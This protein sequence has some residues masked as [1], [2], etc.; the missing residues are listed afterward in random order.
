MQYID[1]L[2]RE[3]DSGGLNFWKGQLDECE[4]LTIPELTALG[5]TDRQNC[6]EVR[7]IN[8][9]A[10]FFVSIEFQETGY[11]VY[12]FYQTG[13]NLGPTLDFRKF[14]ADTQ[15]IQRG[16]IVGQP[17]WEAL[18]EAN[19]V[20]FA[21]AF[22]ARPEFIAQ[23]PLNMTAAAFVDALNA[24]TKDPSNPTTGSL[25]QAQRDN[26]VSQLTNGTMTRAQVLRS[27]AENSVFQQREFTRAFVLMQFYGYLRRNP[28]ASPDTN[29]D[30]Y[31]FWLG[32]LNQFGGNYITSE[33]VKGFITS[34]EYINRFGL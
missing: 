33:M 16:V 3:P 4:T 30:G 8:V 5:F 14:L 19:K 18:I 6:R 17:G 22:V 26:L 28:N 29:F 1:F 12:R 15:E 2:N 21:N 25:T 31:N 9:S 13:F 20:V 11:L 7:R 23:Y 32:K 34:G 10:A 27:I 24:N